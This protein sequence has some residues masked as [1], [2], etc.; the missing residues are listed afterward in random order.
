MEGASSCL[1]FFLSS[2]LKVGRWTS[3]RWRSGLATEEGSCKPER[4]NTT[5]LAMP[6]YLNFQV[7]ENWSQP[8]HQ[9]SDLGAPGFFLNP[10]CSE[11]VSSA[12]PQFPTDFSCQVGPVWEKWPWVHMHQTWT[13]FPPFP[14]L[15]PLPTLKSPS[16]EETLTFH[17]FGIYQ[18]SLSA[19]LKMWKWAGRYFNTFM[20]RCRNIISWFHSCLIKGKEI[21]CGINNAIKNSSN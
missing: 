19:A 7:Q 2:T 15:L 12:L 20:K 11:A 4:G 1:A 18:F 3:V 17:S 5:S 14:G 6:S 8:S 21:A 9:P 10:S 13:L 16:W